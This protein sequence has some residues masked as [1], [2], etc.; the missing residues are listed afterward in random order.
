LLITLTDIS[1]Q[2]RKVLSYDAPV[3]TLLVVGSFSESTLACLREAVDELS[4]KLKIALVLVNI[5]PEAPSHEMDSSGNVITLIDSQQDI[6]KL[7]SDE[8]SVTDQ[9]ESDD[10]P[11]NAMIMVRPDGHIGNVS[12]INLS[13]HNGHDNISV[14]KV[15]SQGIEEVL[16]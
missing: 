13:T 6:R 8:V 4:N 5:L 3:F 12:L 1:S 7:I 2:L 15:V 14:R 10:T 11:P 16:G 9:N